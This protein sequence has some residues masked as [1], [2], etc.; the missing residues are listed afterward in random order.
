MRLTSTDS[1]SHKMPLGRPNL[2]FEKIFLLTQKQER[3]RVREWDVLHPVEI[4]SDLAYFKSGSSY[5]LNFA[6]IVIRQQ[7]LLLS[8]LPQ[9][10]QLALSVKPKGTNHSHLSTNVTC[11]CISNKWLVT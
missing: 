4:L 1:I 9:L 2:L 10:K 3:F 6:A 5:A 8:L 7:H 11:A